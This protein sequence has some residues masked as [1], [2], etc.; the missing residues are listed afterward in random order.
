MLSQALIEGLRSAGMD[1]VDIGAV[2]TPVL[3]FAT[4]QLNT[5][6]GVMVTGSHNPPEYNGFKIM[7][8]GDTLAEDA[9]QDLYARIAEGRLDTGLGSFRTQD[10]RQE[11]I[12]RITGDIQVERRLKIVLDA[13][14]GIAG[15]IAPQVLEGIG[16]DVVPLHCEVDGTFPNHHPDPSD[17]HNLQDLIV[18]VKQFGADVGMAFDGDGDRLGV[19]TQSGDIIYPDRMLMLFAQDVLMRNP[20][21]A[22]IYDVKCSGRLQDVILSAGGSPIMWKTGHSLIKAKMKEVD[23]ELAGEMSGHF[24]FRERWYGFDDG[25]YAAA[26]LAEILAVSPLST[27]EVFAEMPRGVSTPELKIQMEEGRQFAFLAK[28]RE[29]ASFPGARVTTIDGVRADYPQGWGL[30]RCSNT[31]PTL[32]LRFEGDDNPVLNH[33]QDEFRRQLLSVDPSLKLPF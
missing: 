3:Y 27:D 22:V 9:I 30:V 7:L 5:G 1:V 32:V 10:V 12:E 19:V 16:C 15:A 23:A 21:A 20:G 31:T 24:F 14:N 2:P 8:G 13:G 4:F 6:S 25:I 18:A 29:I 28:F 26:R 11:Y 33:I 17:P